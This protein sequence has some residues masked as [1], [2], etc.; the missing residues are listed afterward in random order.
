MLRRFDPPQILGTAGRTRILGSLPGVVVTLALPFA[1]AC[2]IAEPP[3][4]PDPALLG[5]YAL[6]TNL[7][8]SYADSLGY[9][10]PGLFRLD[11][12]STGQWSVLPTDQEYHPHWGIYDGLPSGY[13]RRNRVKEVFSRIPGDSIDIVFP[14]PVGRLVF[15]VGREDG[16]LRGRA[17]WV[18]HPHISFM[19]EGVTVVARRSS[20]D[21]LKNALTRT[22]Y[23]SGPE[24][25]PDRKKA[26]PTSQ[27]ASDPNLG[28]LQ[29]LFSASWPSRCSSGPRPLS[30]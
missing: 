16:A 21:G 19:N 7:P 2:A 27:Y 14:G 28:G 10:L 15:R 8:E 17:E 23:R 22:R 25:D 20:C 30:L 9:E 26:R 6:E 4:T 11:Y 13:V 5:C 29:C 18:V 24:G 12:L 3:P 1:L